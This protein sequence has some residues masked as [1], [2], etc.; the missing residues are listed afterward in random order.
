[1]F[2]DYDGTLSPIVADPDSA[3]MTDEVRD[4]QK[5]SFLCSFLSSQLESCA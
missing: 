2:L 3:V 4:M 5:Q 1:M